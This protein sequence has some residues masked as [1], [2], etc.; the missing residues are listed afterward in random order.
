VTPPGNARRSGSGPHEIRPRPRSLTEG[1][2]GGTD[3]AAAPRLLSLREAAQ[4]LLISLRSLRTLVDLGK[5]PVVRVTAR[6]PAILEADL[7]AFI[8]ARREVV[9]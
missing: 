9:R 8:T 3:P 7:A 5:I 6:R 4:R 1:E 2:P